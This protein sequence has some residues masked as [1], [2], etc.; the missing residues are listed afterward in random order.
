MIGG[1]VRAKTPAKL[2]PVFV[3]LF[4]FLAVVPTSPSASAQATGGL[5]PF[6]LRFSDNANGQIIIAANT[7]MTCPTTTGD[8]KLDNNCARTQAGT[9][10]GN[11]NQFDMR[12]LDVD[13]D[14]STFN[15]SNA[16]LLLPSD[17]R[18]LFAGLYWTGV[19]AKGD[20]IQGASGFVG[21]PQSPPNVSAIG[22]V[23]FR[24]P[25]TTSYVNVTAAQ[26]DTGP[27]ANSSGYTAYADVTSLVARAGRG[28]YTVA[29]VQTSTGGNVGAGWSLVVAYAD[30]AEPLRNL[31]VFDGLQVVSS[32]KPMSIPLSGFKTPSSGAVRTTVGLVAAEGDAGTTGDY[33]TI[34]ENLLTDA[35]HPSNNTENSTIANR[36]AL[37]TTKSPNYPNQ[38]GYD[39]SLFTADGFLGNG[40]TSATFAAKTTNDVYA[41]QAVTFATELYSPDVQLTKTVSPTG[42]VKPGDTLTYTVTATNNSASASATN[43]SLLDAIPAGTTYVLGSATVTAGAVAFESDSDRIVANLGTGATSTLGGTLA[44]LASASVSFQVL[45]GDDGRNGE[46]VDNLASLKFVSPDLGLPISVY[47]DVAQDLEYPDVAVAKQISSSSGSQYVFSIQVTNVGLRST[48]GTITVSDPIPAGATSHVLSGTG[49]NC[50]GTT[51]TTT[52]TLAAQGLANPITATTTYSNGANVVNT[53]L[54]SG[55]GEPTN[56]PATLN[57]EA[58]VSDGLAP[59]SELAILKTSENQII[60]VGATNAFQIEVLNQGPSASTATVITD[61]V[62]AGLRVTTIDNRCSTSAGGS[63]T[64]TIS[65][66]IGTLANGSSTIVTIDTVAEPSIAGSTVTN[67]ASVASATTV[68]TVSD[69]AVVEIRPYTDLSVSKTASVQTASPGDT[70]TYSVTVTNIGPTVA[71]D[72]Q[73]VDVLPDGINGSLSSATATGATCAVTASSVECSAA[74]LAVGN[75]ISISITAVVRSTFAVVTD[76]LMVNTVEVT[77]STDDINMSNNFDEA[78]VKVVPF[79][80]L[81]AVAL[82]NAAIAAGGTSVLNFAVTNNGPTTAATSVATIV[83]DSDLVVTSVPAGCVLSGAS[84]LC[85]LGD[86]NAGNQVNLAFGVKAPSSSP[87]GTLFTSTIDVSS[88]TDDP[89]PQ[90]NSD[91]SVLYVSIPPAIDEIG[92]NS[93]PGGTQIEIEGGGFTDNTNVDIGNQPCEGIT[94]NSP[95][96]ITCTVPDAPT[97]P[98]DVVVTNPDGMTTVVPSGFTY[99][100]GQV[101]P[102]FTG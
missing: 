92:P 41:P 11:N 29:D 49:W 53:A 77:S 55:G 69:S 71:E 6:S 52:A 5:R 21:V 2:W 62:P 58:T 91:L 47:A 96:S 32:S 12:W 4:T 37:V 19:Q 43:V 33:L 87:A 22:T 61:T 98:A 82:S 97:G 14:S 89:I 20:V 10:A 40:S 65:C 100:G 28:T 13:S 88:A 84:Y 57:N 1:A 78:V 3:L 42:A 75:S 44:P 46:S 83:I 64:T 18:V 39:S 54:V 94:V 67:T 76:K 99:T 16:Q 25:A 9:Y 85:Q 17:G 26:I 86:L 24:T 93:G 48:S 30:P 38:L 95:T 90:N 45:V 101:V 70:I 15:S 50:T 74:S 73:V 8:S 80:D 51:C 63:G 23:K 102:S 66:A 35:V 56:G 27:I 59:F 7:L 79:A 36:G 60:S 72:V 31:S 81:A 34:N 68:T